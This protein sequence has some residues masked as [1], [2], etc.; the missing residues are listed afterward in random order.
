MLDVYLHDHRIGTLAARGRGV[1]FTY[2]PEAL[3]DD[4]VPALSIALPKQE[5]SFPDSRGGPY[6]RNLLPEQAFRRLV[7]AAA[8]TTP[9][10]SLGLLGAIGGEC[11][12]AVSVWPVTVHPPRREQY[13]DL[14]P[15]ELAALF[16]PHDQ[17]A[18]PSAVAR[19]RLSLPGVQEKVALLRRPNGRWALPVNGA[20]TSHIL[21]RAPVTYPGLL[22]NELLAMALARAAGLIVAPTERTSL[23]EAV[24]CVE[25]FDRVPASARSG[26]RLH[27]LH[28]EDF[29]QVLGI[30]PERKYEFD[31]G[32]SLKACAAVLRRHSALPAEDLERLVR[33]AGFNYLI[34]NED[35]HAKN[36]A[37]LYRA[38][39]LRLAPNY[40]LV[41]TEIYRGLER[42]MAMKIGGAT[43]VRNVQ[44]ND[45]E[46][47]ARSVG[48]AWPLV[49]A[50]LLETMDAV[51]AALPAA[52]AQCQV[53]CGVSP[54]F[55]KIAVVVE[56]RGA[57]HERELA[58]RGRAGR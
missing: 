11:P 53:S 23:D 27:K 20:V 31:G 47:F 5:A 7:A 8:G 45:W 52:V 56:R 24:L 35:A 1:R 32:P 49:R 54:V 9:E 15:S 44:R 36:L 30:E 4:A 13:R 3:D 22:E 48:L 51:R 26:T 12:G 50:W 2:A 10:D 19:G 57:H 25:R 17:S 42:R 6:F 29:C 33:W 41:S 38:D 18:L 37:L 28:Q 46:R 39:G 21:K 14:R 34:G 40:D 55:R 58:G 43:D 16:A